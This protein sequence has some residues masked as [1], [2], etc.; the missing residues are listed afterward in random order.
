M[1]DKEYLIL[2]SVEYSHWWF[3]FL[4]DQVKDFLYNEYLSL[5]RPL[6]IFDAGCGTGGLLFKLSRESWIESVSGCEPNSFAFETTQKL[7]LEVQNSKIEDIDSVSIRYDVVLCMD[8]LY[9]KESDPNKSIKSILKLL[10]PQGILLLNVAAMPCLRRSHD[11]RV[12]GARR[13]LLNQ[14]SGLV[15]NS[16]FVI[17]KLFYWNSLLT[18]FVFIQAVAERVLK[19]TNQEF[20]LSNSSLNPPIKLLNNI[21]YV[22]LKTESKLKQMFPFPF[23][24]SLFLLARK[25]SSI[26]LDVSIFK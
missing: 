1:L 24:T 19:R 5:K 2:P 6:K 20:N 7:G 17:E 18:P 4:H 22:L 26:K 25:P 14:L 10:K 15:S 11:V 9:H 12:Y 23:G 8:V 3:R 13:F 21:L 16:G